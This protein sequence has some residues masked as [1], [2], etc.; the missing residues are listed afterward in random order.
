M[1]LMAPK[2]MCEEAVDVADQEHQPARL[3]RMTQHI[4]ADT[5]HPTTAL[6]VDVISLADTSDEAA[7][8][9][10]NDG[11]DDDEGG[12]SGDSYEVHYEGP[13]HLDPELPATQEHS[14]IFGQN[15]ESEC[16][17]GDEHAPGFE[18]DYDSC[19]SDPCCARC[20][21]CQICLC[22]FCVSGI[23]RGRCDRC[24]REYGEPPRPLAGEPEPEPENPPEP[25]NVDV[26]TDVGAAVD[27][28]AN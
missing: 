8:P 7:G 24:V 11:D 25:E 22:C 10:G 17:Y 16:D 14:P 20:D 3:R 4:D 28:E 21:T 19:D 23:A 27:G 5:L 6:D 18:S 1:A 15:D 13:D 9:A 2:R 12:D 26:A